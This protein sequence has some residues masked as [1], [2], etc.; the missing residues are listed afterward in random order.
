MLS[1]ISI[2]TTRGC[3]YMNYVVCIWDGLVLSTCGL[4]YH[5]S[6]IRILAGLCVSS[7]RTSQS[8]SSKVLSET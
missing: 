3:G 5:N 8:S 7:P 6:C 2:L 1:Y 4:E